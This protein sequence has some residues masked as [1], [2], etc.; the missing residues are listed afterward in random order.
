MWSSCVSTNQEGLVFQAAAAGL[1]SKL[2][3]R[4]GP[5]VTAI[6]RVSAA[7]RSCPKCLAMPSGL[8]V[9][10]PDLSCTMKPAPGG[11]G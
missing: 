3:A 7:G 1:S 2:L 4:I 9:R 6:R 10:K 11:V 5:C 8:S